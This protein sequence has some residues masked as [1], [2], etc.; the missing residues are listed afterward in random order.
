[1]TTNQVI[2]PVKAHQLIVVSTCP[3]NRNMILKRILIV[4][5][6]SDLS[7]S[8]CFSYISSIKIFDCSYCFDLIHCYL[9]GTIEIGNV[10]QTAEGEHLFENP[11]FEVVLENH[12]LL[13][14]DE[15][16]TE[17]ATP[18]SYAQCIDE[19]IKKQVYICIWN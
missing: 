6:L 18:A 11:Y 19:V 8:Y 14:K 17:Y 5:Q 9:G 10:G 4:I 13:Q 12:D 3:M 2:L 1:M 16:C 15:A 7:F